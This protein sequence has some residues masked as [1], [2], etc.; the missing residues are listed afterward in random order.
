MSADF[1]ARA[2][3][4]ARHSH[5]CRECRY[6]ILKGE[7]YAC[8]AGRFEGDFNAYK[9]CASCAALWDWASATRLMDPYDGWTLGGLLGDLQ[10]L[11]V[12]VSTQEGGWTVAAA[13]APLLA[14]D[15]VRQYPVV[16]V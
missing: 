16:N 7:R 5:A 11:D 1:F 2:W 9:L 10:E 13:Y 3:R 15:P 8:D 4:T 14:I 12:L 6:L